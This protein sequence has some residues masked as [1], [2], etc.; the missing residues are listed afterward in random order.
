MMSLR[1]TTFDLKISEER[2]RHFLSKPVEN[3]KNLF[4]VLEN[5]FLLK[6][7]LHLIDSIQPY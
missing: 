5:F 2:N 7:D 4:S 1:Y 3:I 6:E